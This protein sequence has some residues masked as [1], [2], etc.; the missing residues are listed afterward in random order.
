MKMLRLAFRFTKTKS[1]RESF[2]KKITQSSNIY[3]QYPGIF[4]NKSSMKEQEYEEL[5]GV[6]RAVI[7]ATEH[8]KALGD[9]DLRR[10]IERLPAATTA[11]SSGAGGHPET[12]GYGQGV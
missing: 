8:R 2:Q 1:I 7:L 12:L 11:S 4:I 10:I 3:Y 6:Y 9:S 5:D